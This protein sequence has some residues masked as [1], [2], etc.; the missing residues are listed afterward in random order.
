MKFISGLKFDG[1]APTLNTAKEELLNGLQGLLGKKIIIQKEIINNSIVAGTPASS[2]IIASL[3]LKQ[4]LQEAGKEGFII[5][6][7]KNNQKN[8]TA[9][10]ANTDV[11]VLYG[12]FHFLRL[13]QTQQS[14]QDLSIVSSPK[15]QLRILNPLG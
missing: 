8:I 2:N 4:Q 3:S 13:L 6:K 7:T 11:G 5:I 1:S 10:A 14:I 12:V 15:I 9:I